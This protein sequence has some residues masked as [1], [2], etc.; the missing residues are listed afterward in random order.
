MEFKIISGSF[1]SDKVQL[2]SLYTPIQEITNLNIGAIELL[3]S[4]FYYQVDKK[5]FTLS[6]PLRVRF[7][8]EKQKALFPVPSTI[9]VDLPIDSIE[10]ENVFPIFWESAHFGPASVA[11]T[12][13]PAFAA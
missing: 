5:R 1:A 13:D 6:S 3:A 2:I 10:F 11:I 8:D 7:L 12:R 9:I 4:E